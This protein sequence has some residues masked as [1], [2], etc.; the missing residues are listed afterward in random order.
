MDNELSRL[1]QYSKDNGIEVV[2]T[3]SE[4][5]RDYAAM[6]PEAAKA[7]GFPDVDNNTETKEIL[8]DKTVSETEQVKNL[9]HELIEMRLMQE[10]LE[11]WPAHETALRD[12][13]KVFDYSKPIESVE[14]VETMEPEPASPVDYY[15][16]PVIPA[17]PASIFPTKK[18]KRNKGWFKK[19]YHKP[20]AGSYKMDF[21]GFK[22]Y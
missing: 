9:K 21:E 12:E 1:I 22:D 4:V 2:F 13:S 20:R 16:Q 5:L 17:A 8:I 10:G 18:A 14:S 6:N 7:M 3:D 11:Y 19:G 15:P